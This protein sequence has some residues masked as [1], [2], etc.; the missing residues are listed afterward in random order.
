M[1]QLELNFKNKKV[2]KMRL[3][4]ATY[5]KNSY[6]YFGLKGLRI[7]SV[8]FYLYHLNSE[9][10]SISKGDSFKYLEFT[11]KQVRAYKTYIQDILTSMTFSEV[12]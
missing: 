5:F 6:S 4:E 8:Y 12:L 9:M 3:I 10:N 2:E 11:V 7:R 1:C